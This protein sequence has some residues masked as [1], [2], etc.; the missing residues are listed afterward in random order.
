ML[1]PAYAEYVTHPAYDAGVEA[2]RRDRQHGDDPDI[3]KDL[4]AWRHAD[5]LVLCAPGHRRRAEPGARPVQCLG[6]RPGRRHRRVGRT[7]LWKKAG[8]TTPSI[9]PK[10]AAGIQA[11]GLKVW[12][13]EA[14][15]VLVDL[16]TTEVANAADAFLRTNGIIVRKVGGYGLPHCL[17]V[18][19]GTPE[20]VD[21]AIDAFTEFMRQSRG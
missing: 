7:R 6:R 17:R 19:V 21:L 15:F 1:D 2:G 14:N 4:R 13:S 11:A 9:A 16:E 3:F 12:P 10:L 18:T 20:E 5:R 8:H